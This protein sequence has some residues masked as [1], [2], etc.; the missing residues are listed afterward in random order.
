M[1][2][3]DAQHPKCAPNVRKAP[4]GGSLLSGSAA[5]LCNG[6]SSAALLLRWLLARAEQREQQFHFFLGAYLNHSTH[7]N[8]LMLRWTT[9]GIRRFTRFGFRSV[10]NLFHGQSTLWHF[11]YATGLGLVS[12]STDASTISTSS[13]RRR[14]SLIFVKALTSLNNCTSSAMGASSHS[15]HVSWRRLA[16]RS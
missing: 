12:A 7:I 16:E 3:A 10:S 15:T 5:V 14:W 6:S 2:P 8:L 9:A 4:A 11:P 13:R 1:P